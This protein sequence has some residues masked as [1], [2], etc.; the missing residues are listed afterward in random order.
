MVD[1]QATLKVSKS[2]LLDGVSHFTLFT[3]EQ[4]PMCER[5]YF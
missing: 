5:L 1:G 3:A 2:A 4:R